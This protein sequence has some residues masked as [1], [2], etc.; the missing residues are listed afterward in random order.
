[1]AQRT[2]RQ[3]S[4]FRHPR[5][6]YVHLGFE[7]RRTAAQILNLARAGLIRLDVSDAILQEFGGVLRDKFLWPEDAIADA[8]REIRSFANHVTP[9]EALTVVP[10]DPDDDRILECAVAARSDYLITGDKH[11]LNLRSYLTTQITNASD[12][13]ALGR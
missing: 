9:A 3:V 7:L 12:F 13:L 1:M 2:T 4:A 5:F 10:A 11:L 8:Q 6:K